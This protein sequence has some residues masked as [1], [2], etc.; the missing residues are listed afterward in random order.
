MEEEISGCN[1]A[2]E[3]RSLTQEGRRGTFAEPRVM[4]EPRQLMS[5]VA[6]S[7]SRRDPSS[8]RGSDRRRASRA[9]SANTMI[10]AAKTNQ[11]PRWPALIAVV[12][13]GGMYL[14]LPAGLT[15]GP[16]WLF[17]AIIGVLLVPTVISH[18]AG[19]HHLDRSLGF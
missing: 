17:P 11:E 15:I 9:I 4:D 2:T 12:A 18:R 10:M 8:G 19:R 14:A 3:L 7:D 1:K 13:V 6:Q 16:R 5:P